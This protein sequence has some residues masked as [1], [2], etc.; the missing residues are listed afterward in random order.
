M[1]FKDDLQEDDFIE[2]TE[3]PAWV[4]EDDSNVW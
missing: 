3:L 2:E 4:D 1:I